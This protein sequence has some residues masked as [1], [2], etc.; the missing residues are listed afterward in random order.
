MPAREENKPPARPSKAAVRASVPLATALLLAV[1]SAAMAEG[2]TCRTRVRVMEPGGPCDVSIF[3]LNLGAGYAGVMDST[4]SVSA[5]FLGADALTVAWGPLFSTLAEVRVLLYFVCSEGG[6]GGGTACGIVGDFFV[7]HAAG[8]AYYFDERRQHQL[9]VGAAIGWGALATG[10]G[11]RPAGD[12][13]LLLSPFV[14]YAFVGFIGVEVQALLP[15]TGDLGEHYPAAIGVSV[16]GLPLAVFALM[17][18]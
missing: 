10:W 8:Y 1:P 18:H 16:L 13:G 15:V 9:V 17:G 5:A 11:E 12:G 6:A 2:G 3:P 4:A 14:R 7:G